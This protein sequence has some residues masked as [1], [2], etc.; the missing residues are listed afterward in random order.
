MYLTCTPNNYT[1]ICPDL[2][3]KSADLCKTVVLHLIV[4]HSVTVPLLHPHPHAQ[5]FTI[6]ASLITISELNISI[7][8][9]YIIWYKSSTLNSKNQ[10]MHIASSLCPSSVNKT[11]GSFINH[12]V[13]KGSGKI[14]IL[15]NIKICI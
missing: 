11:E 13:S 7:A 9:M 1:Q 2:Q 10:C 15:A 3:M 12:R 5:L 8:E 6:L 4:G 14:I